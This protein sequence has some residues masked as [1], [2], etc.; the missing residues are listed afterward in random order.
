MF[1][2]V[3]RGLKMGKK[4]NAEE[5][6]VLEYMKR[7]NRPYNVTDLVTNF[8]NTIGKT[9]LAKILEKL[10]KEGALV[11]KTYGKQTIYVANQDMDED[12]SPE[13][14]EAMDARISELK[15]EEQEL[16]EKYKQVQ[17]KMNKL[18]SSLTMKELAKEIKSTKEEIKGLTKRVQSL[19]SGTKKV[20]PKE[21]KRVDKEHGEK[22]RLLKQRKNLCMEIVNVMSEGMS[23]HPRE[24]IEE[25]GLDISV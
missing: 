8:H 2:S 15:L 13:N 24:V 12:Y 16:R 21:R 6:Q 3:E 7:Q 1:A 9:V 19:E 4:N 18:K 25:A 23:L 11:E 5:I 17:N 20:D 14:M 22:T 10:V